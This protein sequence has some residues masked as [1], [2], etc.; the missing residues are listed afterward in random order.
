MAGT[1]GH[2]PIPQGTERSSPTPLCAVFF[3][4]FDIFGTIAADYPRDPLP[5]EPDLLLAADARLAAGEIDAAT[6]AAVA[7]DLLAAVLREQEAAGLAVVA[8]GALRHPDRLAPV[9]AGLGGTITNRVATLAD[10]SPVAVPRFDDPIRWTGPIT[11]DA[12]RRASDA[13]ELLVKQVVVGPYTIAALAT[14]DES[15]RTALTLAL[16]EAGNAELRALV[17]AGCALVQVDEPAATTIG[18]DRTEWQLFAE[19]QRRLTAGLE[20]AHLSLGLL[21]GAIDPTGHDAT[22]DAPYRSYLFDALGGADAWR[23]AD[24]VPPDRGLVCGIVDAATETRDETEVMVWALTWAAARRG[25]ERVGGAP[26][27]SLRRISRHA[28]RRKLELL[29]EAVRIASMG[30]LDEVAIALD[31]DPLASAMTPLRTLAE[32]VAAARGLG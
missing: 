17:E 10:H 11:V 29:G 1:A 9:A 6:H 21:S 30:P 23:F 8:D 24:A 20:D 28:A 26:S 22:L 25:A 4:A 27:G 5:G 15:A 32:T 19:A 3:G 31:P 18:P 14:S 7:D 12:W 2:P 16:A 13:T